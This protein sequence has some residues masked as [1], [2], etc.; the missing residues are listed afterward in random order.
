[1]RII[2]FLF[3]SFK[4]VYAEINIQNLENMYKD[5]YNILKKE[6]KNYELIQ[7]ND[8]G[9]FTWTLSPLLRSLSNMY[10]VTKNQEYKIEAIIILEKLL[11]FR[12]WEASSRYTFRKFI[13]TSYD[14]QI[15]F[16]ITSAF[17][18]RNDNTFMYIVDDSIVIENKVRKFKQKLPIFSL[19]SFKNKNFFVDIK[20]EFFDINAIKIKVEDLKYNFS[21]HTG[22][23]IYALLDS[24]KKLDY[25]ISLDDLEKVF[26]FHNQE[27]IS[28]DN[29]GAYYLLS[30]APVSYNKMKAPYNYQA[31]MGLAALLLYKHTNKNHYREIVE[32]I[33]N[34]FMSENKIFDDIQSWKY[35]YTHKRLEDIAHA[36]TVIR[37]IGNLITD[38]EKEQL[39]II[40]NR[41]IVDDNHLALYVDGSRIIDQKSNYLLSLYDV[42]FFDKDFTKN[43]HDFLINSFQE[44]KY[45]ERLDVDANYLL[46]LSNLILYEKK[47]L[48]DK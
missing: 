27:F 16:E 30:D 17:S 5:K 15:L 48:N 6:L 10:V 41:F 34:D 39:L 8:E 7:N 22:H 36:E 25:K 12:M 26:A 18:S 43:A 9:L 21:V 2:V 44:Q 28:N 38:I 3:I 46:G 47:G 33:F 31:S 45:N 29:K 23:L 1:M 24:S 14:G 42:L 4:F 19:Q 35:T 13:F 37:F 40:V 32:K 11:D 20:K